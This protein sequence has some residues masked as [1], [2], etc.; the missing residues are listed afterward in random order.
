M[1]RTLGS[2]SYGKCDGSMLN[3]EACL[4]PVNLNVYNW[5]VYNLFSLIWLTTELLKELSV[6][7]LSVLFLA[8][9]QASAT[10]TETD[11]GVRRFT[12]NR[13]VSGRSALHMMIWFCN[14]VWSYAVVQKKSRIAAIISFIPRWHDQLFTS[15]KRFKSLDTEHKTDTHPGFLSWETCLQYLH[16]AGVYVWVTECMADFQNKSA[17]RTS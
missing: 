7:D 10:T 5:D 14:T 13:V 3:W 12:L 4:W 16:S 8:I 15:R 2:C 17:R 11:F 6:C 1:P 9:R